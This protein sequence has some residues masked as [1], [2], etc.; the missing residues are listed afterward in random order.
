MPKCEVKYAFSKTLTRN[1]LR[2]RLLIRVESYFT[3]AETTSR[4][5]YPSS[6]SVYTSAARRLFE[7]PDYK[8]RR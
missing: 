8:T 2:V 3:C 6:L 5:C 7:S 4:P 1:K